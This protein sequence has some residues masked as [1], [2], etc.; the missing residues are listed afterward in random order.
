[1]KKR[2]LSFLL[3]MCMLFNILPMNVLANDTLWGD[4]NGDNHINL[5]D[6]LALKQ[7]VA[8]Y[9]NDIDKIAA[10][11]NGDGD[12][13]EDDMISMKKHIAGWNINLAP[14]LYII[15]FNSNGGSS[16]SSVKVTNGEMISKV[17]T[18]E[19]DNAIFLGWYTDAGFNNEF[20]AES[21]ISSSLTLY[22]KYAEL[23]K[24]EQLADDSF[25]LMDQQSNLTFAILSSDVNMTATKVREN[26]LLEI[27]DNSDYVGLVVT[28]ENGTFTVSAE[29][30]FIEGSSYKLTLLSDSLNFQDKG[31]SFRN[32][33]FTITKAEV[34]DISL[35][36]NLIYIK[37]NEIS[38]ITKKDQVMESLSLALLGNKDEDTITGTFTYANAA[39][40]NISDV[41]CIYKTT[42]P[43]ERNTNDDYSEDPVAYVKVTAIN[44]NIVSYENTQ[45]EDVLFLPDTLPFEED[46]LTTYD[47]DGSFTVK[48]DVLDF[49]DPIY[50]ELGL[51][52]NTTVDRGDFVVILE[53]DDDVLYGEVE[54]VITNDDT[55]TINFSKTTEEEIQNTT[56]DYYT[57]EDTDGETM[58]SDVDVDALEAQIEKETIDN[59]F[60][61]QA[62]NFLAQAATKTDGFNEISGVEDFVMTD[63]KGTVIN[64]SEIP[65]LGIGVVS[66]GENITV[67]AEIDSKTEHFGKGVH[68]AVK[69][70]GEISLNVGE[71][72][73]IKIELSATFVEE[74]KMSVNAKGKVIWKKT[75]W[76]PHLKYIGDYQMNANVD[77]YNYTGI[78]LKAV[79]SSAEK[80]EE[81]KI[82]I[83]EELKNLMEEE[84][85]EE[86][87]A[88]VQDLFEA[89]G[90][91]LDN[92]TDYIS[93]IDQEIVNAQG[94]A[95]PFHIFAY[96][97]TMDFV[98]SANIN[99]ALGCNFE[100]ESGTRYCFWFKI[101]AKDAGTSSM[102]LIDETY[103]F[104]FYA[105]GELGIRA[106]LQLEFE[107]G[108]FST[109]ADSV[110]LGTEV[111]AYV[112]LFGYFIYDFKSVNSKVTSKMVGALYLEF[113]I[114]LEIS[115]KAQVGNGI[116]EYNPT[117][118]ENQWPLLYAGDEIN[119]YDFAYEQPEKDD[120]ELI[121]DVTTYT[122]PEEFR[123]MSC[124]NL[125][126]GDMFQDVYG[127]DKFYYT[128]SNKNFELK[129]GVIKVII[130]ENV[131]YQTCDL[132][133]TWK[134]AKLAFSKGDLKRTI[135]L[136]W[137]NLTDMELKE[138]YN[139]SVRV[140]DK[141]IWST[142]VNKGET[143]VL[144]TEDEV[145]E[146]IGY[147]KY[148]DGT[149]NLKYT[150]YTGYDQEAVLTSENTIYN[151]GVT[152][153]EYTL[154]VNDVQKPDGTTENRTFTANFGESFDLSSLAETGTSIAGENYTRYLTSECSNK[155]SGRSS[156]NVIDSVFA[157]QLLS[158]TYTY[159]AK[160]EDNSC[161]VTY[162]F[163]AEDGTSIEPV[164]EMAEKGTVPL[165]DYS[166]Y[167][168]NQGEG[169]IVTKWDKNLSRVSNDTTFTAI[170]SKPTGEKYTIT[171]NSSGGNA[172]EPVQRYE[173]TIITAP[174]QPTKVGYTFDC[175]CSD[176]EHT[177]PYSFDKMTGNSFTLY[178]KWNP[179]QYT[180]SFN[181]NG[182]E[183]EIENK[184]VTYDKAYGELPML[185]RKGYTFNGWFTAS[186]GGEKVTSD[187]MVKITA[188]QTLYAKWEKKSVITGIDTTMQTYTYNGSPISYAIN[189]TSI[190]GFN[191]KYK[192]VGDEDWNDSAVNAGDY[193]V[194]ISHVEDD[195][196]ASYESV[197]TDALIID[198]KSRIITAPTSGTGLYRTISVE[199]VSDFEGYGDGVVE[200]AAANTVFVPENGWTKSLS[201]LNYES[202]AY[203]F[204]YR[205][206]EKS[207]HKM[208]SNTN[209]YVFARVSEGENYLAATSILPSGTLKTGTVTP[210][211]SATYYVGVKT[212]NVDHAGT[213]AKVEIQFLYHDGTASSD[214]RLDS[215]ADDFERNSERTYTVSNSK[216]PWMI[217]GINIGNDGDGS[218][219]GWL[220]EYV[221][222]T[223]FGKTVRFDIN[224]WF[225][226]DYSNFYTDAYKRNI[227]AI[228]DFDNWGGTYNIDSNSTGDIA[229]TYNGNVTDQYGTYNALAHD[230]I[231]EI[232]VTPSQSGYY[233]CFTY[234]INSFTI[235][236]AA[237]YK[238]M[239]QR[240]DDK[241]EFTVTMNFNSR[242]ASVSEFTKTVTIYRK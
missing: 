130:P 102:P 115:F 180:V 72:N 34:I 173:G 3:V 10:D 222:L 196:Y 101:K 31:D 201:I 98:V 96:S 40:L 220:C 154:T 168:L 169:Y 152:E 241:F 17:P 38:N 189:G 117:L 186:E 125:T 18:P 32:C 190:S 28:G 55:M 122:L 229:Y 52:E 161:T 15:S 14:E 49:S 223:G 59:G 124:L 39:N 4:V 57:S 208:G 206:W 210:N 148:M 104:Q 25:S 179:N 212:A 46:D 26:L 106:G 54:S 203:S 41:L 177:K 166:E 197:L 126:E 20:Y 128:L 236:K 127:L 36:D 211:S 147:D 22:A 149:T 153:K 145:L 216:D 74:V 225:D 58:L 107:I 16:V 91:M 163:N 87:T 131:R 66:E 135:H 21:P 93:I 109:K 138:Q 170:C 187:A 226:D 141:I 158:N 227:T 204:F 68:C 194:M 71:E 195:T 214:I 133:I 144:P 123:N 215:S 56:L 88:G 63:K 76:W 121:K 139:V 224:E 45:A 67:E 82:D 89:Y 77:I 118:Y 84:D 178:A 43:N 100:Y 103:E 181:A 165:F 176:I 62:I 75:S 137:T 157:K 134:S 97:Y 33:T 8:G 219:S 114:Y 6:V 79:V 200:Y 230:D 116:A 60:A 12:I 61:Q 120:K 19:K 69:V 2:I 80:E 213:D 143:P 240:G 27:V 53:N 217:K 198:K 156:A 221:N 23:A 239:L 105:M 78:S 13:N 234:S 110:G 238:K 90:E 231:P 73:E 142:R 7:Y 30:G 205:K 160:Y 193:A 174:I 188:P 175:W 112:E 24:K 151:F 113:G 11:I 183:S 164:T 81:G 50:S 218:A 192:K 99:L 70:S 86:I 159:T 119:V 182:G 232:D 162:M 111:G 47:P 1:M 64:P 37:N 167:L 202:L 172:V 207:L 184:Q 228:G 235:D 185:V 94:C 95:D 242:S 209:Y 108:L 191:L 83:S 9:E 233:D 92:E 140:G 29:G 136:V 150:G 199:P 132:T 51:D 171:F 85:E 5:K 129:D 155:E 48:E 146:L 65:L 237:L 44:A 35:N 42:K